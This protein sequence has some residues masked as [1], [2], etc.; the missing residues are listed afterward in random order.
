MADPTATPN[1]PPSPT[2]PP[3]QPAPPKPKRVRLWPAV[4]ITCLLTLVAAYMLER[5]VLP[6]QGWWV[7]H[8]RSRHPS[9]THYLD[10]VLHSKALRP[11]ERIRLIYSVLGHNTRDRP[12]MS[13]EDR[14]RVWRSENGEVFVEAICEVLLDPKADERALLL[15]VQL[16]QDA[17]ELPQAEDLTDTQLQKLRGAIFAKAAPALKGLTQRPGLPV[18]VRNQAVIAWASIGTAYREDGNDAQYHFPTAVLIECL[19][20][21]DE[22]V[23]AYAARALGYCPYKEAPR[24]VPALLKQLNEEPAAP[25]SDW[26]SVGGKPLTYTYY[27]HVYRTEGYQD[28][29]FIPRPANYAQLE[30]VFSL[31][32]LHASSCGGGSGEALIELLSRPTPAVPPKVASKDA[33]RRIDPSDP[34][35]LDR[36]LKTEAILGLATYRRQPGETTTKA[37]SAVLST[38]K[39]WSPECPWTDYA[40]LA[41]AVYLGNCTLPEAGAAL[42][43]LFR[44]VK[45]TCLREI[46]EWRNNPCFLDLATTPKARIYTLVTLAEALCQ[47]PGVAKE[48]QSE[49]LYSLP[50]LIRHHGSD[51]IQPFHNQLRPRRERFAHDPIEVFCPVPRVAWWRE[52]RG[53]WQSAWSLGRALERVGPPAPSDVPN[54]RTLLEY[55]GKGI[56]DSTEVIDVVRQEAARVLLRVAMAGL[57]DPKMKVYK[58][59]SSDPATHPRLAQEAKDQLQKLSPAGD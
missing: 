3:T 40:V 56:T 43:A 11:E 7:E 23:R 57:Q 20:G 15:A 58:Q 14:Y 22:N 5:F 48:V 44:E 6:T 45:A 37:D 36:F 8:K 19:S 10:E 9:D 39:Q 1:V 29:G 4:V 53:H 30:I 2:A 25:R 55:D 13:E 54:L 16:L 35:V 38:L 46:G 31:G 26:R 42:L 34:W 33:A 28:L 47:H 50:V 17:A 27:S 49:L 52:V 18:A 51:L 21:S 59:L 41:A 12:L 32:Q 24:I